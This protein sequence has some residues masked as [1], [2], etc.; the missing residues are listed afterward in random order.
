MDSTYKIVSHIFSNAKDTFLL[1]EWSVSQVIFDKEKGEIIDGRYI[2][3]DR[4]DYI[5]KTEKLEYVKSYTYENECVRPNLIKE[6]EREIVSR[7]SQ[8]LVLGQWSYLGNVLIV[9]NGGKEKPSKI[10]SENLK[11]CLL[12]KGLN[13]NSHA[14]Y[15]EWNYLVY[16]GYVDDIKQELYNDSIMFSLFYKNN[17]FS[18]KGFKNYIMPFTAE[19]LGCGINDLNVLFQEQGD[20]FEDN[21][22]IQSFDFRDF[23]KQFEFSK[24]AKHLYDCA[25][26]IFKYYHN[27]PEYMNK[28]YNDSFYDI[29]NA[30]MNKDL[31][32][33][34]Q[35]EKK[36][37]KRLV[38]TKT[39]KGT[40]GFSRVNIKNKVD[41]KYLPLFIRFFD[42]RDA[43][44]EKKTINYVKVIWFFG[45]EI[46]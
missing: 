32:T 25:L 10:T 35:I 41:K 11:Y 22:V 8:G 27:N 45:K 9:S 34:K 18:N 6:I 20:F 46:I 42:A 21:G 33:F 19:E 31:S 17:Q 43:L 3:A 37:D 5:P 7:Q 26:E 1:S 14:K 23:M 16:R 24:E 30:I 12:S 44:A 36:N 29:T 13:F 38:K 4:Y 39:T 2:K 28:D 15:Y 40:Q